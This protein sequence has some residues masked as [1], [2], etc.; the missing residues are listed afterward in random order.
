MLNIFKR[1]FKDALRIDQMICGD[2]ILQK[3][4]GEQDEI[5]LRLIKNLI[6]ILTNF[7]LI[8]EHFGPGILGEISNTNFMVYLT[9][10]YCLMRKIKKYWLPDCQQK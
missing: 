6:E 7:Q 10:G 4:R 8:T 3:T 2:S 9:N 1:I 5:I